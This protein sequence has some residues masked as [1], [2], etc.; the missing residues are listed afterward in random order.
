MPET[1]DLLITQASEL[2]TADGIDDTTPERALGV[3]R[4]GAVA[5]QADRVVAV[6]T[7]VEIRDR[8]MLAAGGREIPAHGQVIAPGFVDPHTHPVFAGSRE[9]E[10]EYRL[11]GMSYMEIAARGG[12]I[13]STVKA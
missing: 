13:R 8:F 9:E 5:I 11:A 4:D 10:F 3:I 6:G 1:A 12:G 2:L 7:T